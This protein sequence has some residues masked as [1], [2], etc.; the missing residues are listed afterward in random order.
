M[1]QWIGSGD[2]RYR[3]FRGWWI[4]LVCAV[5][6][7]FS[8][9][10]MVVYTFGVFAKPLASEL[11]TS[12]GSIAL[13]VSILDIM[14]AIGAPGAGLLVD[15]YGARGV[16]VASLGGLSACLVALCFVP[17]TL[18]HFYA[19]FALA[20]LIG[21]AT[22]PVTYSRVVA[23]WFDRRR[24]FALGLANSGIGVGAFLT[25]SL[26]QFLI[27]RGG[28]RLGYLGLAGACM[29]VAVPVVWF[30]LRESP[31]EVGLLADGQ[32]PSAAA[33]VQGGWVE[34]T[35]VREALRTRTFW[36]LG[37]IFFS[38][39]A[40][41]TGA[42]AHL[43][44]LLTDAGVSGQTAALCASLF[45]AALLV[46][47]VGNGYL[48]DRFFGPYVAAVLFAGAA[49]AAALL[50]SAFAVHA[51]LPAAILLGLA[52]GAEGDLMPFLVSR[53]FGMRAMAQLYGCM[54]AFFTLGNATGRYLLAAGFDVWGSYKRPL[55]MVFL[56]LVVAVLASLGLGKYRDI[57]A[58]L[59][60]SV[61]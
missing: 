17:P 57:T 24:G 36:Q 28:W 20:G 39:A 52:A 15:R 27:G 33:S 1:P 13:A 53:Y 44:P 32:A 16:I 22:T 18:W 21:V 14:V 51:A 25:P 8:T 37:F 54:F 56:T 41:V 35:T 30:F 61:P 31:A 50:W 49:A 45:G 19:I 29:A 4:V 7:A 10:T 40:C 48:L 60:L 5:G 6:M 34:G 12:R 59:V 55:A 58:R 2:S 23:N 43:V 3:L 11:K 47:R 26:A 46:G 9:G 38:V 42:S